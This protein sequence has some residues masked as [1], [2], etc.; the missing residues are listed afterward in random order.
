MLRTHFALIEQEICTMQAEFAG[1]DGEWD[2]RVSALV[3]KQFLDG[4]L[5]PCRD[6]H[7]RA[8]NLVNELED[9]ESLIAK[10]TSK[11]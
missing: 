5:N 7:S 4:I 11:Y 2:D 9:I 8:N 6:Y 10:V 1:I 3:E